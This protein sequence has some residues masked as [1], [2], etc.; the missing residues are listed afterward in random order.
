MS[1][2]CHQAHVVILLQKYCCS[3]KFFL[4]VLSHIYHAMQLGLQ[5]RITALSPIITHGSRWRM[6]KSDLRRVRCA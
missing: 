2:Q 1:A 5:A 4:H 3:E 6:S